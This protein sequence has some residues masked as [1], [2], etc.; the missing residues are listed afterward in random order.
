MAYELQDAL[1]GG[2]GEVRLLELVVAEAE[3]EAY[4]GRAQR[5]RLQRFLVALLRS[6]VL[7]LVEENAAL[8]TRHTHTS[9]NSLYCRWRLY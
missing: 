9:S 4:R 3:A 5:I 8:K 6:L 2:A 1:K 7:A